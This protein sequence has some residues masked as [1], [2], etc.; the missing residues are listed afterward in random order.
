MGGFLGGD[1]NVKPGY[2][3]IQYTVRIRGNGTAE[4]FRQIHEKRDEDLAQLNHGLHGFVD[5]KIVERFDCYEGTSAKS[6]AAQDLVQGVNFLVRKPDRPLA[7]EAEES[8]H[9]ICGNG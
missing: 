1:Q 7:T 9:H 2:E 5:G 3:P 8:N 6:Q 4:P